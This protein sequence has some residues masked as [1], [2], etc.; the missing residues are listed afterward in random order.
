[1]NHKLLL[2]DD[3]VTLLRFLGEYLS[4]NDFTVLTAA[5]GPEG[6]KSA[7]REHPDLVVLDIMMPGMD[8]WEVCARLRELSDIPIILLTAKSTEA[9][10]LRGFRL[11]VDDYVT[12]PFS[13]A[14]LTA[15]IQAVL[16]RVRARAADERN[17]LLFGDLQID[18]DKRQ[19][20][21]GDEVIPL[22]PTEFRLLEYIARR[23]GRAI[24]EAELVQEIWG[25]YREE[26]TAAVR[27]YIFLLR[28]KVEKDPSNPRLI[29]TVRGFGYRMGTGELK[30]PEENT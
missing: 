1:M 8:G 13:F 6:L 23:K 29:L 3:D 19:A 27:R 7:Y 20:K 22:T 14:E 10:K 15:R 21:R 25:S 17:I 5:N 18:V 28:Q 30:L 26:N 9:D 16:A 24:P 4:N 12:K 11:G 2:I